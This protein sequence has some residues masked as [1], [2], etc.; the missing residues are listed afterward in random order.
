MSQLNYLLFQIS[1]NVMSRYQIVYRFALI[2]REDICVPVTQNIYLTVSPTLV[3]KVKYQSINMMS[4]YQ[5]VYRFVI[6][7]REDMCVP[8]IQD[9]YLTVSPTLVFKVRYQLLLYLT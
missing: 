9:I 3:Y 6:I 5:I 2:L 7:L 8:V 1:M 4:R